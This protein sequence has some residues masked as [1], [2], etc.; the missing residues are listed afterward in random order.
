MTAHCISKTNQTLIVFKDP[1]AKSK[2]EV[3]NPTSRSVE[4]HRVDGCLI[5]DGIRCDWKLVDEGTGREVYIELKGKGISHAVDQIVSSVV[6]LSRP[7]C[8]VRF[9]YVVCTKS[10]LA[11]AEIQILQKRLMKNYGIK[12][13]VKKTV[14]SELLENMIS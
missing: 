11:S 10:P 5:D 1:K 8:D 12:L 6:R 13:R 9:A 2:M 14:Y 3:R 4:L 7:G